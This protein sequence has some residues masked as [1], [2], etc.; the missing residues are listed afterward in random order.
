M[1]TTCLL[2]WTKRSNV[3]HAELPPQTEARRSASSNLCNAKLLRIAN[4]GDTSVDERRVYELSL[5]AP[6]FGREESAF[7]RTSKSRSLAA[8]VMTSFMKLSPYCANLNQHLPHCKLAS[9]FAGPWRPTHSAFLKAPTARTSK[10][11]KSWVVGPFDFHREVME[12]R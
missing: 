10:H 4:Q 8:L 9:Q 5:R 7:P 6:D 3:P 1:W 12:R 11:T 2:T